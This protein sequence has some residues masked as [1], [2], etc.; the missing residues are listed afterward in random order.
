MKAK[1]SFKK[2]AVKDVFL[3]LAALWILFWLV[4]QLFL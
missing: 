1:Y 3:L 4:I 2:N